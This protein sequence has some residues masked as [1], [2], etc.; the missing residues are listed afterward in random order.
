MCDSLDDIRFWADDLLTF[1]ARIRFKAKKG[2]VSFDLWSSISCF[3]VV[4]IVICSNGLFY[5]GGGHS[6]TSIKPLLRAWG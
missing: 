3:C 4:C 2:L 1:A 5:R 6:V